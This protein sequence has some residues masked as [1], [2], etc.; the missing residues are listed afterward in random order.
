MVNG[1]VVPLLYLR[2]VF[3]K[4][5]LSL[6]VSTVEINQDQ[7]FSI[8]RDQLLKT[9][10]IF[11]CAETKIFYFSVEIFKIETFQSRLS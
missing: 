5:L 2:L 11:H 6:G 8:C 1:V 9:V 3:E 10:E 7:D 4:Y